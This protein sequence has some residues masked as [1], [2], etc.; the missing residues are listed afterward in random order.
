M[1][2][3]IR[4]KCKE[5][6]YYIKNQPERFMQVLLDHKVKCIA[7]QDVRANMPCPKFENN[8]K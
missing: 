1:A 6:K 8:G 5:C 2:T 7:A 3:R 4:S